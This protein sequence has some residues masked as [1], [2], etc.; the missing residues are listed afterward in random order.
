MDDIA[1]NPAEMRNYGKK[2]VIWNGDCH[3]PL[4]CEM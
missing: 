3:L 2:N 1:G 4:Q